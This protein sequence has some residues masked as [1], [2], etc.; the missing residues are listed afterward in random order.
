MTAFNATH[1]SMG[2]RGERIYQSLLQMIASGEL[3]IGQKLPPEKDLAEHFKV[4]RS[5]VR[6]AIALLRTDGQISTKPGRGA[7]VEAVTPSAL[8]MSASHDAVSIHQMFEIR[9]IIEVEV[10][11]LA[12]ERRTEKDVKQIEQAYREME[13][14]ASESRKAP[15][16]DLGFHLA[17]AQAAKNPQLMQLVQ[18]ISAQLG[19]L[20]QQAWK[21][22][23]LHAGGPGKAQ[24]EHLRILQAIRDGDVRGAKA[25]ARAHLVKSEKRLSVVGAA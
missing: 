20:I 2:S 13:R 7:V 16:V 1:I 4:G 19:S 21:N 3:A 9:K 18:F 25:A 8:R 17:I 5:T 14:A 23:A 24:A 15:G 6:E 12:A 22:S 10:A 11:G